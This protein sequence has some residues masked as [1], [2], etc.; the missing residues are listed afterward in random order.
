MIPALAWIQRTRVRVH[1]RSTVYLELTKPRITLMVMLTVALGFYLAPA[2]ASAT[3]IVH[4]LL[5][6]LLSCSGAGALN[7]FLE[8]DR[9]RIM[10]RTR[11]R[12]LP[13]RRI[14]PAAAATTGC[15][16]A[17]S[18]VLYLL[19]TTN[20]LT[21]ALDATILAT[22][23]FFYTP[24]KRRS[25]LSTLVGAI[26]G[27]LPPV[28]GW[29]AACNRLDPGALILFAIVFLWQV[30]HFLAIGRLYREDYQRAGFAVLSALDPDGR[31]SGRQMVLYAAA[32]LPVSCAL[33]PA[34]VAGPGY[35][36]LATMA[37]LGY[38]AAAL[39]AARDNTRVAARRVLLAS[40]LYLPALA[41]ALLL[42]RLFG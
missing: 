31:M 7:Q 22:Y 35:L 8:R 39:T 29:T 5:G 13:T 23:L 10:R 16:L 25:T 18:G 12:P 20:A 38:V 3:G 9:D 11:F 2:Q 26:P 34:G 33:V 4:V 1:E 19:R 27:A 15:L 28:M 41:G 32:L 40:I 36:A 42:E 17:S 6:T 37:G 24:L 21:A 30:P 14:T